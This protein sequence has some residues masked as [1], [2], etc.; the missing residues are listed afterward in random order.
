MGDESH[1]AV[2]GVGDGYEDEFAS[3]VIDQ[4]FDLFVLP[5][6][7]RRGLPPDQA[8]VRKALIT[9]RPRAGTTVELNDEAELAILAVAT[10]PLE[11]GESVSTDDIDLASAMSL[12]PVSVDPD[13]G[14]VALAQ[15]PSGVMVAFDFTRN[16]ARALR[17]LAKAA[18]FQA[19]AEDALVNGRVSV[20]LDLAFS[21]AELTVTALMYL[22]D[23]DPLRGRN[24]HG[25]RTGWF[26]QW[27][28][29]G[30][31]PSEYHRLLSRLAGLR[32][33]ARYGDTEPLPIEVARTLVAKVLGLITNASERIGEVLPD[34]PASPTEAR[35]QP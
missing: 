30:N 26:S 14:W 16:R 3:R 29:L 9:L 25:R 11:A 28:R 10:R 1:V 35:N 33:A 27:T 15:L 6:L 24:L 12:R 7:E 21:A 13:A 8:S 18:S 34:L 31:S 22:L 17:L 23:D 20:A 5:E 32:P 2:T 19:T 4:V